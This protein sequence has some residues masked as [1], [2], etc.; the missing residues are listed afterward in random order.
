MTDLPSSM[1]NKIMRYYTE[2]QRDPDKYPAWRT[3]GEWAE[4]MEYLKTWISAFYTD[5][6]SILGHFFYFLV[7]NPLPAF[8][9]GLAFTY[10]GF[11][12]LRSALRVARL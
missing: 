5:N 12:L 7:N 1:W 9:L 2:H 8:L 3:T 6:D 4:F 11:N 10:F